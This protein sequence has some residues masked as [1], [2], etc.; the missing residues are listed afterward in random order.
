MRSQRDPIE[1]L[2][3]ATIEACVVDDVRQIFG[4]PSGVQI[5]SGDELHIM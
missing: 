4:L 1:G 5:V 2:G 3:I